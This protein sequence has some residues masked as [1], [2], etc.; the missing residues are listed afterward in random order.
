MLP[1]LLQ[2]SPLCS[3]DLA[4]FQIGSDTGTGS[5]GR[6]AQRSV[7][8]GKECSDEPPE[9]AVPGRLPRL[10]E[11]LRDFQLLLAVV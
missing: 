8:H 10:Q 11:I 5:V 1:K 7:R 9:L 2:Q 6:Q 3:L 4:V